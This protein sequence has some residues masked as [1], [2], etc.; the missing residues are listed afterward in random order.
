MPGLLRTVGRTAVIAG[1]ASSVSGRV[2]RRQQGRW[3]EQEAQ[4]AAEQQAAAPPSPAPSGD[5][6]LERLTELAKLH[7]QGVLSDAEFAAAK[8]KILGI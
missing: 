8:A 7:D 1:T 5:D 3:A 4:Q 2:Q 6:S